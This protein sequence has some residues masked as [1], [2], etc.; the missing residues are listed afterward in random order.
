MNF[1]NLFNN[2]PNPLIQ[3]TL[4]FTVGAGE[5]F[6][7]YAELSAGSYRGTADASNT[8][9]MGFQDDTGIEAVSP[10]APPVPSI[11]PIALYTLVPGALV[12]AG[13][14]AMRRRR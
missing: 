14:L 8:L 12:G 5:T 3:D 11:D 13:M 4:T 7:V 9:S 6:A 1:S 2:G 10:P